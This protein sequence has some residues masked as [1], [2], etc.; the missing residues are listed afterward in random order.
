VRAAVDEIEVH[1]FE[2]IV[3]GTHELLGR[4]AGPL[5]FVEDSSGFRLIGRTTDYE[6][7]RK[8]NRRT[9]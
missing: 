7:G 5:R 9:R 4:Q 3:G 8:K 2:V 1:L 6:S